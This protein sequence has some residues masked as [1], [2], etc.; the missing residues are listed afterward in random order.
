MKKIKVPI[1]VQVI[2]LLALILNAFSLSINI[3]NSKFSESIGNVSNI[4]FITLTVYLLHSIS[5]K[6]EAIKER[7]ETIKEANQK[8]STILDDVENFKR[9]MRI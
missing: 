4:F 2:Y 8:L 5:L 9:S 6:N 1:S 7:D 3:Y